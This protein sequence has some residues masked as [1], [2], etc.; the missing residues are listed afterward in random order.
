MAYIQSCTPNVTN[1]AKSL[2][3]VVK[4]EIIT[5]KPK[6]NK[7]NWTSKSA[8]DEILNLLIKDNEFCEFVE[9]TKDT[10]RFYK[11]LQI[12]INKKMYS[13]AFKLIKKRL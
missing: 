12:L 2:Y 10:I 9:Y 11:Y 4:D 8:R 6:D 5:P 7:A 13:I 3:F 1:I